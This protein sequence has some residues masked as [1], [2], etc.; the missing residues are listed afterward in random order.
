MTEARRATGARPAP[1]ADALRAVVLGPPG[2]GKGTQASRVAGAYQV[3][4]VATGDILRAHVSDG[5]ALGEQAQR[6]MAA[7]ELVPDDIVIG[8]VADR[9]SRPDAGGFVLDGF[10]RTVPQAQS[11]EELL[12]ELERP[13]HVVLRLAVDEQVIVARLSGRRVC[14]E[15]GASFHVDSNPPR[16]PGVCDGCGGTLVQRDDDHEEVITHR[17]SVYRRQTEPLEYFYWQR[18]LLR[19][20]EALGDLEEVTER[21]LAV[22]EEHV[23]L[24]AG[25]VRS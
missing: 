15:C 20:V 23:P 9:L 1:A 8:M 19:D 4:H 5:T 18:G 7:G 2:A 21:M 17:L 10:P 16:Q 25:R 22:L 24:P 13:L 6:Y 12:L 14:G 11:L 3:P